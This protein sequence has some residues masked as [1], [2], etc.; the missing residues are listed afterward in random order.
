MLCY[1]CKNWKSIS[2]EAWTTSQVDDHQRRSNRLICKACK[3]EGRTSKHAGQETC[4]ACKQDKTRNNFTTQDLKDLKKKE[5]AGSTYTLVCVPCKGREAA[6]RNKLEELDARTCR[7]SCGT[8]LFRHAARCK[9]KFN[10]RLTEDDL[11]F[12]CFRQ[13]N[14]KK[15]H[16]KDLDYYKRL[17]V[18]TSSR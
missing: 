4:A 14:E 5:K 17:G 12:M 1:G 10:V 3:E 11:N 9:A 8:Q 7:F 15:Y 6:L 18:L 13:S 16:L 2:T